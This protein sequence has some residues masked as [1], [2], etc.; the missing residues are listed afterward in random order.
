MGGPNSL[1]T[2]DAAIQAHSTGLRKELGLLDLVFAQILLVVVPDFFG[3]AVKAGP[4]HVVLWLSAILLFFIPLALI[5]AHLNR[6]MPLEGGLYEWARLAF[7][8][9]IGFLVAWNLWLFIM[10]YVA[11]IGLVTTTFVA[12]AVPSLAWIAE[13]K[14]AVLAAS[15]ILIAAQMLLASIG[16]R[17]GKWFNNAGSIA[18]LITVGV[19]VALPLA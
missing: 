3:T 4:S 6:L 12:Y 14:W 9:Q 10:L 1:T 19:L 8:D 17:V 18:V 5:V 13:N 15:V 2:A 11:I 7:N 16:F